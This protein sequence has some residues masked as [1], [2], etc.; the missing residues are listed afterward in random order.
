[1]SAKAK[2]VM[3]AIAMSLVLFVAA[4]CTKEVVKEVPGE[5]I[6]VEKEVVKEVEVPGETII[7]EQEV[8]K[9]VKVAGETIIVEKEPA[10][11][12]FVLAG[13][14]P[15]GYVRYDVPV[16][17]LHSFQEAP[18][19]AE[20]VRQGKLPPLENRL[21]VPEDVL[22]IPPY[23]AIGEYGGIWR[24][25]YVFVGDHGMVKTDG[26]IRSDAN[27]FNWSANIVKS[28]EWSDDARVITLNLRRGHKWSDGQPFTA[29]DFE[30]AWDALLNNKEFSRAFPSWLRSPLTRNPATFTKVDEVTVSY[31]FDDAYLGA[32]DQPLRR[33]LFNKG[34]ASWYAPM[35]YL[36]QF[37]P[38]Y[39]ENKGDLDKMIQDAGVAD[40]SKL[41]KL[42][43]NYYTNEEIP[44]L[45]AWR[46]VDSQEGLEWITE[47][48]PYYHA[49]DTAGNQLPYIDRLHGTLVENLEVAALK[50]SSGEVDFQA[51]HSAIQN[52][53]LYLKNQEQGGYHLTLWNSISPADAVIYL[54]QGHIEDPEVGKWIRTRDFRKAL[55]LGINREEIQESYFLGMGTIR[56]FVPPKGTPFYPGD[57]YDQPDYIK[58]DVVAA[59]EILDSL[60]LDKRDSD[61]FRLRS[62]GQ[63]T[64]KLTIDT[65]EGYMNNFS[66]VAEIV[67]RNWEE[68]GI[69]GVLK[70]SRM[71]W[72]RLV[73]NEAA[74]MI[75]AADGAHN[76]WASVYYTN[77]N[78][79][80]SMF[81]TEIG[82]WYQTNGERGD[83]PDLEMYKNPEGEFPL[84]TLMDLFDE[85]QQYATLS[86]ERLEIAK[87]IFRIH[88]EEIFVIPTVGETPMVKGIFIT[89]NTFLNVPPTGKHVSCP[90][91]CS[92][93]VRP[94]T[95]YYSSK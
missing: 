1:M 55:S 13:E 36:K 43:T 59:N 35:H 57:E 51:R 7:V 50:H 34:F 69:K 17:I 15:N 62:D 32:V 60:G 10:K 52:M 76:P 58:L 70:E 27:G 64:L 54:N 68:I 82:A 91:V 30:W 61:G 42:K 49:V 81:A 85:G 28:V 92:D 44:T 87:E 77:P 66:P 63:G 88:A 73:D 25:L 6:I 47:R 74:I 48:N 33:G 4:A 95:F 37:H 84:K 90:S 26:L 16:P 46:T 41:M 56:G 94:E 67:I 29:D 3:T 14:Y 89:S 40:W 78:T 38:D 18:M 83:A 75:W 2:L 24:R 53:P 5:T 79:Y 93:G 20:L 65:Q 86:P 71:A 22:V 45:N 12:V 9:E 39:A 72:D 19:L 8:V 80:D 21:P 11:E 31:T 23:E